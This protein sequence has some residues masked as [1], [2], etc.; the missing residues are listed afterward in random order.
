[1]TTQPILK[2][3]NLHVHFPIFGGIFQRKVTE[4]KAVDGISFDVYPGE[5]LGI[6]G[7][8]GCGKSTVGKALINVL[9]L[10][11]PDVEL[12]GQVFLENNGEYIDLLSLN[13]K[14]MN[15]YRPQIQMIFQDPFSSLNPRMLVGDIVQEPMDL[16]TSLSEKEKKEKVAYLLNKVGLSTEQA[17]R[18]PHEF[19]GGQRQRIGIARALATE[20]RMIIADEPVSALDVSIQAQVINLMMDLQEEFNL[21]LIFIAHDLSVVEHISNRIGVMYLGNLAELGNSDDVYHNPKHPYTRSLL[22]AVPIPDP[23]NRKD[24]QRIVLKGDVPSP[25]AKPSGCGFRTRCPIV[26]DE[27]ANEI[28]QFEDVATN[29]FVACQYH[30]EPIS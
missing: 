26:K 6:V 18:Y 4:V 22:S 12:S 10:T 21:S 15:H 1:M 25:L 14:E 30:A 7:E 28:P 16:H 19:S 27:C 20:P 11:A 13:K 29:H 2:I 24:R 5:I 9:R 3:R 17:T 8:S 23:K